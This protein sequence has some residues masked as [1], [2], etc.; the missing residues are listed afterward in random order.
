MLISRKAR[1]NLG[2]Q[3]RVIIFNDGMV[4]DADGD[5]IG[6]IHDEL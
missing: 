4:T 5:E 3:D 1:S 2:G 6:N